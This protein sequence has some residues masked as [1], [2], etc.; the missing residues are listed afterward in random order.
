MV[1]GSDDNN[2]KKKKKI[3]LVNFKMVRGQVV[4]DTNL[5]DKHSPS[6]LFT[7]ET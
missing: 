3:I 7:L 4:Q 6:P 5:P 1:C 2:N